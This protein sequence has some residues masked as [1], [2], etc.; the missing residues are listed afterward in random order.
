MKRKLSALAI[1]FSIMMFIVSQPCI[2]Y[3]ADD[4]K[5]TTVINDITEGAKG[6]HGE[7]YT[8]ALNNLE[9]TLSEYGEYKGTA[10][11]VSVAI[12]SVKAKLISPSDYKNLVEKAKTELATAQNAE[13]KIKNDDSVDTVKNDVNDMVKHQFNIRA[14]TGAATQA[15]EGFKQPLQMIVGIL[16]WVVIAG[17]GLITALDIAYIAI[18]VFRGWYT[19]TA[20]SGSKITG[21]TDNKTGEAK[22]RWVSDDAVYAVKVAT[23]GEGKSPIKV[24]LFKRIGAYIMV[25]IVI[26]MLLT[27]NI[28]IFVNLALDLVSGIIKQIQKISSSTG[29]GS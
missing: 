21:T 4:D 10:D 6:E 17:M 2:A 15:L 9:K 20:Q 14:D 5:L 26:F 22:L 12:G 11:G 28:Q 16:A 8:R 13:S 24:Y 7:Y 27:G 3:A 19:D 25:A 18:P 1:L 23:V 29:L